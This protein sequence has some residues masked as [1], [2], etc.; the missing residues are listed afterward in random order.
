MDIDQHGYLYAIT[1]MD[2][3]LA[4]APEPHLCVHT[5]N[6]PRYIYAPHLA[7]NGD[8]PHPTTSETIDL[9]TS[10]GFHLHP[11]NILASWTQRDHAL[12]NLAR[13][14]GILPQEPGPIHDAEHTIRLATP[15]GRIT[16]ALNHH[17]LYPNSTAHITT[18][19]N[20]TFKN[21]TLTLRTTNPYQARS[22]L[23]M[24]GAD[25]EDITQTTGITN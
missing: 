12:I 16:N 7:D 22:L 17:P 9:A 23:I 14:H 1:P 8:G 25:H 5:P 13:T 3:P 10:Q 21:L 20:G 24:L 18:N 2:D 15:A 11:H 19:Q 6:G 4:V